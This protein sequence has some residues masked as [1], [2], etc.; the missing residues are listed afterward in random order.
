MHGA[1]VAD[2]AAGAAPRVETAPIG[3]APV[4]AQAPSAFEPVD[5]SPITSEPLPA[6]DL[7]APLPDPI[8]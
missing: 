5:A 3:S 7:P 4:P 1:P 6:D 8:D 2:P